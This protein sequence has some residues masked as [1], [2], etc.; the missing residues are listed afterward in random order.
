MNTRRIAWSIVGVLSLCTM[1]RAG[2]VTLP[3]SGIEVEFIAP[4][5]VA[6]GSDIVWMVSL[7]N[8]TLVSRSVVVAITAYSKVYNGTVLAELGK[9]EAP[10]NVDGNGGSQI[11]TLTIPASVY[12]AWTGVTDS[13]FAGISVVVIGTTDV[14]LDTPNTHVEPPTP[15]LALAPRI[16]IPVGAMVSAELR[17]TNPLVSSL[18]NVKAVYHVGEGL[19][20]EGGSEAFVLIG[21]VMPGEEIVATR[22]VLGER[23][24]QHLLIVTL[25]AD[26]LYN[27]RV[28]GSIN[29]FADCNNNGVDDVLDSGTTSA[30]CNVNSVPDECEQDCD[31]NNVPDECDLIANPLR[32]CNANHVPDECD[33][34]SCTGDPRCADCNANGKLDDCDLAAGTSTDCNY[35]GVPDECDV[36]SGASSDSN[37]NGAV[38]ATP[39]VDAQVANLTSEDTKV[40][41]EARRNLE[42]MGADVEPVLFG[43]LLVADWT[44]RPRLLEVLSKHGRDFAKK[45][46]RTGNDTEKIYAALVYELSF[47]CSDDDDDHDYDSPEFKAMVEALLR[48]LKSEDKSLRAAAG[49][50]LVYDEDEDSTVFFEH[51]HEIVPALISSFDTE[52]FI[53]LC[54]R[55]GPVDVVLIVIGMNLQAFVG[56]RFIDVEKELFSGPPKSKVEEPMERQAYMRKH[57]SA[58]RSTI[59]KLRDEWETWWKRHSHLSAVEIGVLMIERSLRV[60]PTDPSTMKAEWCLQKWAGPGVAVS[61]WAQ[62]W[63]LNKQ[64]YRGPIKSER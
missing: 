6:L 41:G 62:W 33:I 28:G 14:M 63:E 10:V 34:E 29:V 57:L 38:R 32:D 50:A 24:G 1:A 13:F 22:S 60:L 46:L 39:D 56:D 4:S 35:N 31:N 18:S 20:V 64:S 40:A 27:V 43:K 52:L 54:Q 19:S 3:E 2:P 44:L 16:P 26:Q 25:H 30:D 58:K 8:P 23:A 21:T 45:K 5:T 61:D 11:V 59:D 17:W 49:A 51:L 42:V 47:P 9:T 37:G 7:V 12:T 53:D 36:A 55:A 48:A 15:S